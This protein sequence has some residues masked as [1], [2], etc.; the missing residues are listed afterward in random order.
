[1]VGDLISPRKHYLWSNYPFRSTYDASI[2]GSVCVAS[3]ETFWDYPFFC[4]LQLIA[5]R[6]SPLLVPPRE[7]VTGAVIILIDSYSVSASV[8][9]VRLLPDASEYIPPI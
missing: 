7:I 1:M 9:T 6:V 8:T 2:N 3:D 5:L 4:I